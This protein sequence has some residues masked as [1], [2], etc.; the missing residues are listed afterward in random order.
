MS[1]MSRHYSKDLE[2]FLGEDGFWFWT[3]LSDTMHS[4]FSLI[5]G[6][7]RLGFSDILAM[8]LTARCCIN[9]L[10]QWSPP[11]LFWGFPSRVYSW[12]TRSLFFPAQGANGWLLLPSEVQWQEEGSAP[13]GPECKGDPA[14][15]SSPFCSQ[16][17][18]RQSSKELGRS[19]NSLPESL[20]SISLI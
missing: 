7:M 2:T 12:S 8:I 10:Q 20:D 13:P 18:H 11:T 6:K 15:S 14:S 17:L 19:N 1:R 9:S 4:C 3:F 5:S 16:Y